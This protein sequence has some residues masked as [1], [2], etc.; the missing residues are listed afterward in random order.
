[1]SFNYNSQIERSKQLMGYNPKLT[2]NENHNNYGNLFNDSIV[3]VEWLSPDE[4]FVIFLDELID[5]QKQI[6]IGNIW[7]NFDNFKFFLKH[8]FEVSNKISQEIKESV[9]ASI[10]S[11]VITESTQDAT[12]LKPIVKRMISEEGFWDSVKQGAKDF[13]GWV[14]DQGKSAVQG[15]KDFG[16]TAIRGG[17]EFFDAASQGDW[18]KVLEIIGKG[19]KY[20]ARKI[21]SAMYHP[22]GLI[23]DSILIAIGVGKTVQWIPWAIIVALDIYEFVSGDFEEEMPSWLRVILFGVDI[24]GLVLAGVAAKSAKAAVKAATM[25]IKT[26]A[27]MSKLIAKNPSLRGYLESMVA[28][29]KQVPNFLRRA[30]DYLKSVF[31]SGAKFI[32]I[33][34]GSIEKVITF[35]IK[36]IKSLLSG[37]VKLGKGLMAGATTAGIT[38][39]IE[40]GVEKLTGSDEMSDED[41]EKL[42]TGSADYEG[43][44]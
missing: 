32:E 17:K 25:G 41:I 43:L 38:Y 30:V 20:T 34:L 7:E 11:L 39:G 24:L 35:F 5:V 29:S 10:N 2:L 36:S 28:N 9:L 4:K 14:V 3:I 33:S 37:T 22:V 1:M 6:K 23:L 26:E 13:G 16:K 12:F 31:P 18:N 44:I 27:E 19:M 40:K 21:R 42:T 15:V 8:S